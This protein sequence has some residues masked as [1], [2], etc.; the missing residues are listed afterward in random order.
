MSSLRSRL[1]VLAL[2]YRHLLSFRRKRGDTIDWSTSIPQLRH[3]IEKGAA[4]FGKLPAGFELKPV[5][6]DG[7]HAEWIVPAGSS[8][9]GVILYFHGGGYVTGSCLAHR[10]IVSKF[11][12]ESG[13]C[14][15]V[16][17]YRLA[18]EHPFPAA[19]DDALAAYNHLLTQGTPSA[20]IVFVGDS[21]GGG[22]SLAALLALRERKMPLPAAVVALSPWTDVR[23]TGESWVSNAKADT[24]SW[25][26]SETVF[27]RYYAGDND[28]GNPLISPL[29]GDLSGLP[30]ILIFAGGDEMLLSDSTRFAGIA[31]DAGVAVTLRIGKGMFHCYPACAPLFP[32]AKEAMK[33]ICEFVKAHVKR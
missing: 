23:N 29:Y 25:K 33:E 16:F 14:A 32:E 15:L 18:P 5:E 3:D 31:K 7:L 22:L 9:E 26:G 4:F 24:L 1:F 10:P 8:R 13:I 30:P 20:S 2:K 6:I 11:V 19:L 12:K 27:A 28:P 21:A 17:D